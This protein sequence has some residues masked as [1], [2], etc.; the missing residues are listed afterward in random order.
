MFRLSYHLNGDKVNQPRWSQTGP[1]G[2]RLA[3]RVV[4]SLV[5][6]IILVSVASGANAS[7]VA[8]ASEIEVAAG[9]GGFVQPGR[10]FPVTVS[11]TTDE[12]FVGEL[13]VTSQGRSYATARPV[14][15]AGGSVNEVTVIVEPTPYDSA[16]FEIAL[17]ADDGTAA[18]KAT[19]RPRN[20]SNSDLVGVLPGAAGPTLPESVSNVAGDALLFAVEPVA[21]AGGFGVLDPLDVIVVDA[22]DLRALDDAQVEHLLG[23]VSTGGRLLVDEPGSTA[24]PGVPAEW[25]P[26]GTQPRRAGM[27]EI[28]LTDGAAQA[29]RWDEILEPAPTRTREED[30]ALGELSGF[31]G[32][33]PLSWSLGRDAGFSLPSVTTMIVMLV[34]YVALVGPLLWLGLKFSRR[35]GLAWVLV[36][37]VAVGFTGA[38]WFAGGTYRDG[39]RT[40]HGSIIQV[41][42]GGTV[43]SSYEL[44]NS[45]SGG[46]RSI[47]LP[48]GWTPITSSQEGTPSLLTVSDMDDGPRVTAD[49]DAG[50]FALLG[51]VGALSEYDGTLDVTATSEKSG[52]VS[53]EFT[54]RLDVDLHDV[55]VFADFAGVNIGDV[56]AGDTVAY[57][58]TSAPANTQNGEPIEFT[59]WR[60]A[61]PP[62][63]TGDFDRP[64]VPGV[65]NLSLWS[66]ATARSG[67]NARQVGGVVVAGWTDELASPIDP[68]VSVGRTLMTTRGR[69]TAPG[70]FVSDVV[71]QRDVVRG[72]SELGSQFQIN[73][74]WGGGAMIRFVLPS[75]TATD[76]A[77]DDLILELPKSQ[78]RVD[79]L[80]DGDWR[81][82]DVAEYADDVFALPSSAIDDGRVYVKV[83]FD[84]ERGV[85]ARDLSVR[86]RADGDDVQQLRYTTEDGG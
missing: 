16:S 9:Y 15:L 4:R 32:G 69:V 30:E 35:P 58:V 52:E 34:V 71:V 17:V 12:L 19:V 31:Y 22:T 49:L 51:G 7:T 21:L 6:S 54:N 28:A 42:A 50:G 33:E 18:A 78:R 75:A 29:G 26:S 20:P 57:S 66:E 68:S 10:A 47:S 45:R 79:L 65:V 36:P 62:E 67:I 84:F 76:A 55:V 43:A 14:E 60:N 73:D 59:V 85:T 27:G 8:A 61:L 80:V 48:A 81:R 53:G 24:I 44:L 63:W 82:I 38:I 11:V 37:L 2:L 64:F 86:S 70:D 83:L 56:A 72:P 46:T 3:R 5:A 23:W 25:Q 1:P 39:V 41:G 40:A 13:Q 77:V 74:G